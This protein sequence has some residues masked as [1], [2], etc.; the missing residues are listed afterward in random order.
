MVLFFLSRHWVPEELIKTMSLLT[1]VVLTLV[2]SE[3]LHMPHVQL[4]VTPC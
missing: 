4:W 2:G 1:R 3:A